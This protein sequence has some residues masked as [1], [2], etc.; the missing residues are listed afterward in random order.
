MRQW[1]KDRMPAEAAEAAFYLAQQAAQWGADQELNACCQW[2]PKLPPW[3]ANDL[4]KHRRT[5]APSMKEQALEALES[6]PKL[7]GFEGE[8]NVIRC[9]LEQLKD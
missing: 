9:A 5:N 6:T 4:R 3:S 8:R 7:I 2:L 1:C